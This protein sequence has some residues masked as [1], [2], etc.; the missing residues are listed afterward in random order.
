MNNLKDAHLLIAGGSSGF[1]LA[2]AQAASAQGA[3]L[4]LV[5]RNSDRLKLAAAQLHAHAI[6]GDI[7][8]SNLSWASQ[9]EGPI[10]HVY[11]SAGSFV[12]GSFLETR[13]DDFRPAIEAR[14]WGPAKLV[15]AVH[16]KL[17]PDASVTFSG[18]VSTLRPNA[19]SWVTNIATSIADQM[20]KA[21]A[22]ELAPLR[23]NTV[24][25]GFTD[26][27]MWDMLS[28]A[29]RKNYIELFTAKTPTRRI[30]TAE[31]VAAAVIGLMTNRSINGQSI[32]VDG[33]YTFA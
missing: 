19:G 27:P 16:S 18:G 26:T 14:L 25:A 31:D 28:A 32:Y 5:A 11:I 33:G 8:D 21:F 6:P 22:I 29:D 1:G 13:L 7:T 12:G 30:S 20:A 4:T 15:Q 2:V 10:D 3:K 24:A 17:S 23:F 9:L